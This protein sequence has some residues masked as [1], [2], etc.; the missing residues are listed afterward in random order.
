MVKTSVNA[1]CTSIPSACTMSRFSTP[2]RTINP[3]RV[4]CKKKS[5]SASTIAAKTITTRRVLGIP[6]PRIDVVFVIHTGGT[7]VCGS[8]PNPPCTNEIVASASPTV[9]ST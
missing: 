4:R 5:S 8:L 6:A 3:K 9:T 2:A 7:N 1:R